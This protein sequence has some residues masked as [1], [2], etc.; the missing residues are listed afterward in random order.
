MSTCCYFLPLIALIHLRVDMHVEPFTGL[1]F[2]IVQGFNVVVDEDGDVVD[3]EVDY[4][5]DDG[6]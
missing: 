5:G 2:R 1:P 4:D 3:G 6:L